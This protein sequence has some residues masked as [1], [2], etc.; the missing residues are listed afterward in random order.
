[1][2]VEVYQ[3]IHGVYSRSINLEPHNSTLITLIPKAKNPS[4]LSNWRP[5]SLYNTSY[6]L[7]CNRVQPILPVILDPT[8]RAFIKVKGSLDNVYMVLKAIHSILTKDKRLSP[9]T[10]C[11]ALK[12][13]MAKAYDQLN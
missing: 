1:M 4:F 6:K 12:L 5:I 8:Q 3:F 10:P 13:D 7:I 2:K 11:L 9:G